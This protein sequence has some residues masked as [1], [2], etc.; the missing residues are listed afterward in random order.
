MPDARTGDFA[1]AL[2]DL[3]A[4][5]CT[6]VKPACALCPWMDGLRGASARRSADVSA[7]GAEAGGK[8]S[9]RRG[10]RGGARRRLRA[11]AQ[12]AAEGI[13]RRH[14]RSAEHGM[15]ARLRRQA[16][17][18]GSAAPVTRRDRDGGACRAWSRMCSRISRWSLSS[19]QPRCRALPAR[20]TARA[21][22]QSACCTTRRCPPSCA[23]C[24]RMRLKTSS[25]PTR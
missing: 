7:Q 17:H 9:P 15:V 21:G 6:P 12:P 16:G 14:D 4:T 2:M 5:I 10:V 23:R 1:Q 22:C 11:A 24:W 20:P 3:G 18:A 25:S 8:T 13:A 19:M